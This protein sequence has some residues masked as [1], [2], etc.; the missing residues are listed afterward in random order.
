HPH[1]QPLTPFPTRRS[2]DLDGTREAERRER[3]PLAAAQVALHVHRL[4]GAVDGPLGEDVAEVLGRGRA[5]RERLE[6]PLE[7]GLARRGPADRKS[8]RLN[9]SHGSISYA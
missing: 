8:T 2:S 1:S 5:R 7:P 9:S 3:P 6:G 4:V